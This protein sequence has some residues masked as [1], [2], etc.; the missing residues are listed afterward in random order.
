MEPFPSNCQVDLFLSQATS[1]LETSR[2]KGIALILF[3]EA[4]PT[5]TWHL[6]GMGLISGPPRQRSIEQREGNEGPDS[7]PVFCNRFIF[8][9]VCFGLFSLKIKDGQK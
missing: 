3:T 4:A 1:N 8:R 7:R 6:G 2:G 9:A 5:E